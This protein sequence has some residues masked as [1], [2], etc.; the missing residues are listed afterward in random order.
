MKSTSIEVGSVFGRWQVVGP[1]VRKKLGEGRAANYPVYYPCRCECGTERLVRAFKLLGNSKSCGCLMRELKR[2][3]VVH[4]MNRR[5]GKH[6]LYTTWDGMN[7][8]CSNQN[9]GQFHNYGA[10]G[11]TVDWGSFKD[12]AAWAQGAGWRYGLQIDRIDND[13]PYAPWNCRIVT[14]SE[15]KRN[16]RGNRLINAFGESKCITDWSL[17]PRCQVHPG[18]ISARIAQGMSAEEAISTP[19]KSRKTGRCFADVHAARS[20]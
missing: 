13:R 15:N 4:G 10:R 6:P 8:R 2:A 17:D 18:T 1:M 20:G 11:I 16:K 7:N 12:F 19:R 5:S 9:N 3:N 14:D